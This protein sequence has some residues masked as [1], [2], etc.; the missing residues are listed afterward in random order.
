MAE[1]QKI[2]PLDSKRIRDIAEAV[3]RDRLGERDVTRMIA[4]DK[5]DGQKLRG[6][7]ACYE[8]L[9]LSFCRAL[10]VEEPRLPMPLADA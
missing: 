8:P 6:R 5:D 2:A 1:K 7:A 10:G 4:D 9:V 3:Y